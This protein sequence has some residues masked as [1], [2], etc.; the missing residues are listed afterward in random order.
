MSNTFNNSNPNWSPYLGNLRIQGGIPSGNITIAQSGTPQV[1]VSNTTNRFAIAVNS[2]SV[3]S[4]HRCLVF[5]EP[6]RSV[7]KSVLS[8]LTYDMYKPF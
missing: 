6:L 4:S 1:V 8:A 2:A 3:L 5:R 7:M